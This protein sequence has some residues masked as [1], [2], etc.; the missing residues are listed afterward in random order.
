LDKQ[1]YL[2][3]RVAVHAGDCLEVLKTLADNSID[4]VITDPP[5]HLTSIVNRFGRSQMESGET[6]PPNRGAQYKRLSKG[7]MG[8]QWD[9]G[10]I[11][12]RPELWAEVL[13]VLKPG[14]HMFA[15]GGDRT[16][17][18]M[19]CAIEDAGF[20]IRR[21]YL[22]V[23]GQ[24]FPKSHDIALEYEKTLCEQVEID[25][26]IVWVYRDD[27]TPLDRGNYR[28]PSAIQWDG[29][30]TDVK[31]A[32]E[33][34]CLARKPLGTG[35]INVRRN[36]EYAI[37]ERGFDGE[38]SWS[39]S[40]ESVG[41]PKAKRANLRTELSVETS[42]EIAGASQIENTKNGVQISQKNAKING[43]QNIDKNTTTKLAGANKDCA[44]KFLTIMDGVAPVVAKQNMR[45]SPSIISLAEERHIDAKSV[46]I[47]TETSSEDNFLKTSESFAG[48]ATGLSGS[49]EHV[50]IKREGNSFVWPENLPKFV[51]S[52]LLNV[53]ENVLKWG[54]GAL[55]IDG[56]RIPTS[57]I[58]SIGSNNH[59]DA[60]V[61][62]STN[63]LN[64]NGQDPLG[65]WPA[66]LCH[67]GS[68]EVLAGFP[69]TK[70]GQ[71]KAHQVHRTKVSTYGAPTQGSSASEYGNDSGS[72]ARFF[73]CAKANK[74]DRLGSKHP[75]VK[76][77]K[78]LQWLV[79]LIAPPGGTVLDCFAGTGTTGQAAY[80][81]GF[82][83]ILIERET[84]YLA[85][86]ERRMM[87][88]A[89]AKIAVDTQSDIKVTFPCDA[90]FAM[91]LAP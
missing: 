39:E 14:G 7:F 31:P 61:F 25:E 42:A 38:F 82:S 49:Q 84:E 70:S 55:N 81:E 6:Q 19:T 3:G 87:V 40:A 37:R 80:S 11:A 13:R 30:G 71:L 79:R 59:A 50:L 32:L 18:R 43:T 8:K 20:E 33:P 90:Q 88:M 76:P 56:C 35:D 21:M 2:D 17:H 86:I 60:A 1:V 53:A 36:V 75:T 66:N 46:P 74:D 23:Y 58:M 22:W 85:D 10:D 62:H 91:E 26:K 28:H 16:Y 52:K 83:A 5:Y 57:D 4:S 63:R 54:T 12:F 41:S 45:S 73:Y 67:D 34:I 24:G 72:A 47:F 29:F 68:P 51:Q 69:E 48:I 65:R 77:I 15:F 78:L 44:T 89:L 64:S 27:G 9:G